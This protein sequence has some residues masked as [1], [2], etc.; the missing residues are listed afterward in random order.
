MDS[1]V[2]F[3]NRCMYAYTNTYLYTVTIKRGHGSEGEWD[4]VNRR[5]LGEESVVIKLKSQM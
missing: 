4:R 2:I 3:R 1:Q 5:G